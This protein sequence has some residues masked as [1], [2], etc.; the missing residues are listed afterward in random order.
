MSWRN[1]VLTQKQPVNY[2]HAPRSLQ[3]LEKKVRAILS[4]K[5]AEVCCNKSDQT[6]AEAVWRP[7]AGSRG[8]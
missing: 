5:R 6:I 3:K 2:T 7:S 4:W 8:M 1:A